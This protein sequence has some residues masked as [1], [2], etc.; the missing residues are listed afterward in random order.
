MPRKP[1]DQ[2]ALAPKRSGRQR[3]WDVMRAI[4][5]DG[6]PVT[7]REVT[8][9][10]DINLDTVQSYLLALVRAG[11][12]DVLRPSDGIGECTTYCLRRGQ[13]EAPRVTIRGQAVTMGA[14]QQHMWNVMR[15]IEG[16]FTA[17]ELAHYASTDDVAVAEAHAADYLKRLAR[18]NYLQRRGG[19]PPRYI[20]RRAADTGPLAPMIQRTHAVFDANRSA[21]VWPVGEVLS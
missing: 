18:A 14:A 13:T 7:S 21:I 1:V 11:W 15:R 6:Q 4:E 9:R 16:G 2:L 3:M 20:F 8:G 17:A 19:K 10:T 12:M 5:A